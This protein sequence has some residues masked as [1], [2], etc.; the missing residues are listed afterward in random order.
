VG[1]VEDLYFDDRAWTTRYLVVNTGPWLLGRKVLLAPRC[2]D[3]VRWR[4]QELAVGLTRE[5][6]E[7]SPEIDVA[8]PVSRQM[9]AE[10][11][12]YYGWAPY[13]G[14]GGR[15]MTA[16][17]TLPAPASEGDPHLRST[18]EVTGYAIEAK[19]GTI[20]HVDDLFVGAPGWAIR[21]A[22]VDTRNWLPGRKVLIGQQW[23]CGVDWAKAVACV[24]LT[25]EQVK[26]SPAY[27]PETP[28]ARDYEAALHAHYGLPR[29]WM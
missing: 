27:D 18:K 6:V 11:H 8:R 28:V 26:Q 23:L 14:A 21:Y 12:R 2:V 9:E 22:V 29:Y 7:Q 10:L 16:A 20:G 19:D 1:K 3:H 15:V 17:Q 4:M 13:W 24:D 25:R 5:Q